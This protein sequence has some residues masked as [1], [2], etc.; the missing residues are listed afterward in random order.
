MP[1]LYFLDSTL[2]I[3]YDNNLYSIKLNDCMKNNFITNYKKCLKRL[4][5][6]LKTNKSK[7]I[8][9]N[10][11]VIIVCECELNQSYK[12]IIFDIFYNLGITKIKY[13]NIRSLLI[14][15]NN[16]IVLNITDN[17]WQIYT[18]NRSYLIE[19]DLFKNIY[20]FINIFIVKHKISN[21]TILSTSKYIKSIATKIEKI[22]K[23]KT[24]YLNEKL[25]YIFS[26]VEKKYKLI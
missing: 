16:E 23:I 19:T 13:I 21:I 17:Y 12:K 11:G 3:K 4:E 10:K 22:T 18:K 20:E 5:Q 14:I 1:I 24:Y 9:F 15:K 25:N 7:K 8:N 26:N 2:F 6:F